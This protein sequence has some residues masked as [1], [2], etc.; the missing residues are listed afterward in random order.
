MAWL[1]MLELTLALT[2]VLQVVAFQRLN[3]VLGA[4]VAPQSFGAVLWS[5]LVALLPI[6]GPRL[7]SWGSASRCGTG[8]WGGRSEHAGNDVGRVYGANTL[9]AVAGSLA[10]GFGM[11]LLLGTVDLVVV[12]ATNAAIG[13]GAPRGGGRRR[14]LLLA[15]LLPS[16]SPPW[17]CFP[18]TGREFLA[19]GI[20]RHDQPQDLVVPARMRA[21]R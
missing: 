14:W 12:A 5:Q 6:L 17:R 9:G 3:D 15:P 21:P 13:A 18:P 16:S 19:A 8:W 10:A 4:A 11:I 1:G 20:F 7:F 2:A